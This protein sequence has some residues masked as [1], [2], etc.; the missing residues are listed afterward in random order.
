[1]PGTA[2][3]CAV[4]ALQ[5][6]SEGVELGAAHF[7]SAHS[8]VW[9]FALR[10]LLCAQ[11]PRKLLGHLWRHSAGTMRVCTSCKVLRSLCLPRPEG[12]TGLAGWTRGVLLAGRTGARSCKELLWYQSAKPGVPL[13]AQ[14]KPGEGPRAMDVC[15]ASGTP[16]Q[17]PKT[18]RCT[19]K[20][21]AACCSAPRQGTV[22]CSAG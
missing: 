12:A 16:Q 18:H 1:M 17:A 2:R 22:S 10:C 15:G 9:H 6:S 19:W 14:G 20:V 5:A 21:A 7:R 13:S 11:L 8:V 4:G 3:S